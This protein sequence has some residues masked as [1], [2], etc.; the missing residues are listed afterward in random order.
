LLFPDDPFLA[1][2]H[3]TFYFHEER[4]FVRDE[5][6]A[7]GLFVRLKAPQRILPGAFFAAGDHL[8]R[9]AGPLSAPSPGQPLVYGAPAPASLFCLEEILEGGRRGRACVRPGPLLTVGRSGCDLC[10]PS[11]ALLA[12]R[13]CE[14]LLDAE[15]AT[16]R[17]LGTPEGT[18][19]RVAPGAQC[20]LEPGDCVRIGL[21]V[22]RIEA[23]Q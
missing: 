23:E 9:F 4:L 16:L 12:P 11:D 18:Y 21:Q 10:F 5:G 6:A 1:P 8:L 15:G 13:H 3:A 22:L 7:S 20:P 19:L 14:L 2:L 17:D